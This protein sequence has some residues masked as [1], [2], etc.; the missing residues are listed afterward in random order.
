MNDFEKGDVKDLCINGLL[1]DGAHHKQWYF[2]QILKRIIP[3]Y[4][5]QEFIIDNQLFDYEWEDGIAP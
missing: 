4:N 3:N 5:K 2:E 1:T